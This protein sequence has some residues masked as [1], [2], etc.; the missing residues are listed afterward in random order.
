MSCTENTIPCGCESNP[1]GCKI[2]SDDVSYQGP[3]L[4]CTGIETCDTLT[5]A[6]QKLSDYACS[7]DMVQNIITNIINN[8]TLLEQFIT[9][10]N[11]SVDCDT[12][13]NCLAASTTTTTT[14]LACTLWTWVAD[15]ALN[16]SGL[17]YVNC[18]GETVLIPAVDVTDN[19]GDICVQEGTT[20][21]WGPPPTKGSYQLA[22]EGEACSNTTTTTTTTET[23]T[24]TT[25]TTL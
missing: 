12:V 14:T 23:P 9:I 7:V 20:P 21:Q 10:V 2:S 19:R 5:V 11:E 3:N 16:D 8:S 22:T 25:T 17:E 4:E 24:T 15:G 1:C 18:D 13:Y 6:I